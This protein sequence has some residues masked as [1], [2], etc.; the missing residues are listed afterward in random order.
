MPVDLHQIEPVQAGKRRTM[1][2]ATLANQVIRTC[3]A[4]LR[5]RGENGIKVT[6]AAGG[7]V[8]EI[9][10]AFFERLGDPGA[11]DE[12][13]QGGPG[14]DGNMNYLGAWDTDAAY[15]V[16]DV[17]TSDATAMEGLYICYAP[18]DT[19]DDKPGT[20]NWEDHWTLIGRIFEQS[21]HLKNGTDEVVIDISGATA[22][23]KLIQITNGSDSIELRPEDMVGKGVAKMREMDVCDAGVAKKAM[24]LASTTYSA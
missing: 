17:V 15:S 19:A 14:G 2:S 21:I 5:M 1:L 18:T 9:D 16:L 24:I 10:P 3:N 12:V 8:V 23:N 7:A 4:F 11:G 22:A 13:N 6:M 20:G